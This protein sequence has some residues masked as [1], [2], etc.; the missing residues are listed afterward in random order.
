MKMNELNARQKELQSQLFVIDN[1]IKQL[2]Q[3]LV[4][5][6]NKYT[7]V[8]GQMVEINRQ[9]AELENINKKNE[10]AKKTKNKWGIRMPHTEFSDSYLRETS[11][12]VSLIDDAADQT[13]RFGALSSYAIHPSPKADEH[14]V[15]P[16]A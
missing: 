14:K 2:N 10:E 5:K 12:G 13:Y 16:G 1:E 8:T 11:Y 15:A 9:I 4:Q 6:R 3:A 7:I